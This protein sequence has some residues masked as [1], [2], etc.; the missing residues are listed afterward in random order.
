MKYKIHFFIWITCVVAM[1]CN[2][3]FLDKQPL[4]VLSTAGNLA[5][6]NELRLYL[7]QFYETL[8]GQPTVTGG[9][10]IAFDDTN[11]DNLMLTSV[12]ARINGD[13]ALSNAAKMDEYSRIRAVN[14]FLENY[15]N[16][17]G[18]QALINGY[19]GEAKFFRAWFYFSL[20]KK[21]GDVTWV[22]KVLSSDDDAMH[23]P[24]TSRVLVIDSVL[25]DL[26]AAA[27]L[28]PLRTNSATM[29]V[30]KDVALAFK[31]RVALYE[32][33]WQKYHKLK[34]DPFWTKNISDE[35]IRDYFTQAKNAALEVMN[36]KRWSIASTGNP[37]E[38]YKNLFLTKDLSAST[39]VM[40]WRKYNPGENIGHS[41]SKYLSTGGGDIGVTLSLVD[42][43]LTRQ[44]APFTGTARSQAQATYAAELMPTLRDPRLSQ[45]VAIPGQP[46]RPNGGVVAALPPVNQ[47]GFNRNTTGFPLYKY[48][49]Y[50]DVAATTDDFKSSVPAIY[51][52]YAEVL[53]NYAEAVA[54]LGE[55]ATLIKTALQPLRDRAGMPGV[56]FNREYNTDPAYPFKDLSPVLQ[57]VRRERRIEQAAEGT[58]L[59][60]ILRWAAADVLLAKKRPLGVLFTGSNMADENTATGFYKDAMLYYDTPP[61]GKSVNFY[62]TGT[63]GDARRYMDP[64]QKVLPNGFGFKLQRDYLLPIQDR[65]LLLTGGE[66]TQN[67][68]W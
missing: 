53:L 14:Y 27:A 54:E 33:T 16:A 45:T 49:E 7:N 41:I 13:L 24:R 35:K 56:D 42:D 52:R 50:D 19:L 65:M 31:S 44:G 59:D 9:I 60:D 32:A 17:K 12:N 61:A 22:S 40:L 36:S 1:S 47:S 11:S 46:L 57:S 30:H 66:W 68:G 37:L 58:R 29:R 48:I 23:V 38:D 25:A 43:Y 67:P 63:P 18:E 15:T 5:S 6:T 26:D 20:I 62:L 39:E 4:D 51:F 55:D 10:G 28:L 21:Y 2:K 8:P 3:D 64:Y 34:A